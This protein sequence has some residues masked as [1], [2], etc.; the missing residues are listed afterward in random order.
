M[1]ALL[2]NL[3]LYNTPKTRE[4]ANNLIDALTQAQYNYNREDYGMSAEDLAIVFGKEKGAELEKNYQESYEQNYGI[5]EKAF[6]EKF[7]GRP[8][9]RS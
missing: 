3:T 6:K 8:N 1:K 4:E 9:G 5:R 7:K 2:D